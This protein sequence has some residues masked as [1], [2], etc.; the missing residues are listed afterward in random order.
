MQTDPSAHHGPVEPF[1][2]VWHLVNAAAAPPWPTSHPATRSP[3]PHS[4][5]EPAADSIRGPAPVVIDRSGP[6]S[7]I[8][9]SAVTVKVA[10]RSASGPDTAGASG[11]GLA[12][13]PGAARSILQVRRAAYRPRT[14]ADHQ[15]S[16][17]GR[18][19]R[20]GSGPTRQDLNLRPSLIRTPA[21]ADRHAMAARSKP[22]CSA[23][24]SPKGSLT[25]RLGWSTHLPS[26]WGR[27]RP[28]RDGHTSGRSPY[29]VQIDS[30][31]CIPPVGPLPGSGPAGGGVGRSWSDL[32]DDR[33]QDLLGRLEAAANEIEE[34][35]LPMERRSTP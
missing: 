16:L 25:E 20:L 3:T 35:E 12:P 31:A 14:A 32:V 6:R 2:H 30:Y 27:P 7:R 26:R 19:R 21:L 17:S 33:W 4:A 28:S 9:T 29:H 18:E 24:A 23:I 1:Q 34:I 13:P 15:G 22:A 8:S 10:K 11:P 5:T